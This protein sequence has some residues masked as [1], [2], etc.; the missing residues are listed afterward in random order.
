MDLK[1]NEQSVLIADFKR[2]IQ[3]SSEINKSLIDRVKERDMLY[4]TAVQE[5]DF[6]QQ[7]ATK[8]TESLKQ[9]HTEKIKLET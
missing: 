4:Q 7:E 8:T 2:Q 5:K 9:A 1:V 3:R 6:Y